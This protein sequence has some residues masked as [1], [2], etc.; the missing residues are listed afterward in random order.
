MTNQELLTETYQYLLNDPGYTSLGDKLETNQWGQIILTPHQFPHSVYQ[1]RI[2]T[3]LDK[4]TKGE[5]FMEVPISTATGVK[6][7]DIVWVE[8]TMFDLVKM[9][10]VLNICPQ[11]CIE[12]WSDANGWI[13][14][15]DKPMAYFEAGAL[16]V[17]TCLKGKMKFFIKSGEIE[18]SL[19]FI[20][21]PK[22]IKI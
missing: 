11:I 5:W 10:P 6:V 22:I 17:W 1:K 7:A 4:Y 20:D 2:S 14:R 21:F 19:I 13:E 9:D 15:K 16:E 3:L 8:H 18:N 12:V